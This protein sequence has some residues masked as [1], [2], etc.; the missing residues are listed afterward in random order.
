V[1]YE[2]AIATRKFV[3]DLEKRVASPGFLMRRISDLGERLAE[4]E[5]IRAETGVALICREQLVTSE[6]R[7]LKRGRL[8]C[9]WS[10]LRAWRLQVTSARVVKRTT[11]DRIR[12][13]R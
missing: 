4:L 10:C 1:S 6:V 2:H 8:A 9:W 5:G 13:L 11:S 7:L 12:Y 3:R